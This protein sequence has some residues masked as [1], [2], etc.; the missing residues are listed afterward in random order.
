MAQGA[1]KALVSCRLSPGGAG[2]PRRA[3]GRRAAVPSV[4]LTE[5][6]T[7]TAPPAG[8]RPS[9]DGRPPAAPG[10]GPAARVERLATRRNGLA[11]LAL[12]A[13]AALGLFLLRPTYPNYDSYYTLLWGEQLASGRLPDYDVLRTPTPHPL[14][15]VVA[16]LLSPLGQAADRVL[17]LLSLASY[18][19]LLALLFRFTQL[20]LGTLVALVAALV[21]LTRTDLH[22]FAL[23]AMV[24]VQ[25]LALVFGAAVLELRRPRR[26]LPV[27]VLLLLAG[28]L[29]PEAWVLSGV[30]VLWLFP[31]VGWR[32]LVRHGAL[33]AL[34]PGLWF[35][36][37]WLVTGN[38]LYSLTSTREVAGQF[39]RQRSVPEAVAL[40]PDFIGGSEKV[41]NVVAGG[42]GG[43]LAL[44]L[45]RARAALPL[46]LGV[47]GT[48]VFLAIAAVGLSVIPRYLVIPSLILSLCV[49]V[50]LSG[51]TAVPRGRARGLA[52]VLAALTVALMAWRAPSYFKDVQKLNAQ[53]FFVQRQHQRLKAI[54]ADRRVARLLRDCRPVTVPTHSAIP[55]IRYQTGLGKEAL[56]ASIAQ[57]RP[58]RRGLL[59][60]GRTFNFEPAA[61]RAT[62]GGS[63]R[64]ARNWWS[65][66]PLSGFSPVAGND[67]WRVYANCD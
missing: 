59:L 57:R 34:A 56:Q 24:D 35:L 17:V 46:A 20:L 60:V 16:A 27:L 32:S 28:L 5:P 21:L 11:L 3:A 26:G 6:T 19:A 63:V 47:L 12:C 38:P 25:F 23:R 30:Y 37:D 42:L 8:A 44:W 66:Y 64:S 67:R 49:G 58:P 7:A 4:S 61:A 48:A 54:L 10:R 51:W 1:V 18:L 52:L 22:F 33:V 31:A 50:A 40:I 29:R 15:T 36:S 45:L 2:I 53:T 39:Q 13:L 62:I 55:V 14:A 43:L 41:V 9:S 65:N